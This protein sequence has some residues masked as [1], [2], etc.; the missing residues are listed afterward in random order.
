MSF[1][2][3]DLMIPCS[4]LILLLGAFFLF[5]GWFSL[6]AHQSVFLN[7]QLPLM[8]AELFSLHLVH[9]SADL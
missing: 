9:L 7:S 6:K 3:H 5:F 2:K 8:D 4:P 1:L